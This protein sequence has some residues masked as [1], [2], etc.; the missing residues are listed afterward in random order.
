MD[1]SFVLS[2]DVCARQILKCCIY[3]ILLCLHNESCLSAGNVDPWCQIPA[4]LGLHHGLMLML[5]KQIVDVFLT[6]LK[7][8]FEFDHLIR[9]FLNIYAFCMPEPAFLYM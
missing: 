4:C 9:Q 5:F 1:C 7:F 6:K 2:V 3:F 8:F